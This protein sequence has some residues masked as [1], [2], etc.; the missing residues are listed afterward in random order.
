[1]TENSLNYVRANISQSD[2]AWIVIKN[3]LKGLISSGLII[4]G[5]LSLGDILALRADFFDTTLIFLMIQLVSFVGLYL[6]QT[7]I[8]SFEDFFYTEKFGVEENHTKLFV[9]WVFSCGLSI[10]TMVGTILISKAP[11]PVLKVVVLSM[12]ASFF[13]MYTRRNLLL[14]ADNSYNWTIIK[15]C[16]LQGWGF[17]CLTYGLG[18]SVAVSGDLIGWPLT[19][20]IIVLEILFTS[21][22]TYMDLIQWAKESK[23]QALSKQEYDA[24]QLQKK[25][26]EDI[27][28]RVAGKYPGSGR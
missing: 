22:Y 1:M 28:N 17:G 7:Q 26:L 23:E 15:G 24:L 13:F 9:S 14:K 2:L 3:A 10:A 21:I 19:V 18:S 5:L 11:M 8:R 4:W 16:F 20:G 12:S 6:Y 25:E 27:A